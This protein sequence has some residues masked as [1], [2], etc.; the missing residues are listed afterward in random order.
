MVSNATA[1]E[2][3]RP[4]LSLSLRLLSSSVLSVMF[5]YSG[6]RFEFHT[7]HQRN[8]CWF[9]FSFK[10]T[11]VPAGPFCLIFSLPLALYSFTHSIRLNWIP[12]TFRQ[13]ESSMQAKLIPHIIFILLAPRLTRCDRFLLWFQELFDARLCQLKYLCVGSPL[14]MLYLLFPKSIGICFH[15]FLL[16]CILNR[17]IISRLIDRDW[18]LWW[19]CY[20]LC[21]K[22]KWI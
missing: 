7:Q 19:C 22:F 20:R 21:N 11:W 10:S 13:T 3:I 18:D 4:T 17:N 14:F 5:F 15:L 1:T 8:K 12:H 9:F 2:Y 16:L 6:N